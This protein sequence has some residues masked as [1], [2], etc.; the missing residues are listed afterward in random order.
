MTG[1]KSLSKSLK[2]CGVCGREST[3]YNY[4]RKAGMCL[5]HKHY[6][7]YVRFGKFLDNIQRTVND[8]NEIILH[9]DFAELYLYDNHG[10]HIKTALIDIEDVPKV[11]PLK[12]RI[13]KKRDKTYVVSGKE[14]EQKYLARYVMDY[15]GNF[16]V[17]HIDSDELNNQKS[18][19]RIIERKYNIINNKPKCNNITTGVR[20]VSYDKY[21]DTYNVD[22]SCF[23]KRYY[24]KPVNDIRYAVYMR[25]VCEIYLYKEYRNQSN[26]SL[27]KSYICNIPSEIKI[28]LEQYVISKISKGE[29]C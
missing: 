27:I 25:L 20:G 19:L 13:T 5:C 21:H 12:W 16:E 11:A 14:N 4:N 26:D 1:I 8:L 22:F 28:K 23:G 3:S 29:T 10:M 15:S 17:D 18:N 7:Q 6:G 2:V 24:L 9:D